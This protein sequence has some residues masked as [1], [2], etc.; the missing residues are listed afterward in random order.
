MNF[1]RKGLLHMYYFFFSVYNCFHLG[2]SFTNIWLYYFAYKTQCKENWFI[3]Q[4]NRC[5]NGKRARLKSGRSGVRAPVGSNQRLCNCFVASPLSMH[6]YGERTKSGCVD[7]RIMCPSVVS[8][9]LHYYNPAKHFGLVQSGLDQFISSSLCSNIVCCVIVFIL[10]NTSP[11]VRYSRA[12]GSYQD[13][14][15]RELMLTRK[16]L[17]KGLSVVMA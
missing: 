16:L 17:N 14:I 10:H 2:F 13:V 3:N 9:S 11:L 7:I 15:Y 8:I 4:P 12:C 1:C 6:H 5:C